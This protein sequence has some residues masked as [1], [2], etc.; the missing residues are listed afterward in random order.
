MSLNGF[1]IGGGTQA[2]RPRTAVMRKGKTLSKFIRTKS[3]FPLPR[4]DMLQGTAE[5]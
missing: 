4:R 1:S 3:P 2:P 5:K